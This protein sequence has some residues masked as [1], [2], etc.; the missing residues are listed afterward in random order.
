MVFFIKISRIFI[1]LIFIIL[2]S[3]C[4]R[5]KWL[6][7]RAGEIFFNEASLNIN[8]TVKENKVGGFSVAP[9]SAGDLTVEQKEKIEKWLTDNS[10]NRYG[11]AMDIFYAGGT[12]LFDEATGKSIERF[13]YILK[14]H[15]D[16]LEKI[17]E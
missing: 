8:E 9:S 11:D 1:V 12:P 3:G 10:L 17:G 13:E 16:I 14:N 15:P 6:D 5:L 7:Q 2:V 4:A